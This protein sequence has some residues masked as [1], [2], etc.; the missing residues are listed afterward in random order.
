MTSVEL[1]ADLAAT[2]ESTLRAGGYPVTVVVGDA[3]EV[4]DPQRE[5]Y[6]TESSSPPAPTTCPS[7][8]ETRSS[9]AGSS[10]CHCDCRARP[11]VSK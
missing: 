5:V 7:D 10:S 2:A 1:E 8:G 3:H 11:E 9:R 6:D 4:I